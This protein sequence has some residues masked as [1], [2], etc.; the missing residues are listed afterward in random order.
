MGLMK[1]IVILIILAA[2]ITLGVLFAGVI[3]MARGKDVTGRQSNKLMQW[4]VIAQA[5]TLL[6]IILFIAFAAAG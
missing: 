4:R 5:C 3:T 1:P 2:L 6:L